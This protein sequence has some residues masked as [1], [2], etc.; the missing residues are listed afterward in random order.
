[1]ATSGI[2]DTVITWKVVNVGDF[3]FL[4]PCT[5][6]VSRMRWMGSPVVFAL[7]VWVGFFL[8]FCFLFFSRKEL[9]C[10][11]AESLFCTMWESGHQHVFLCSPTAPQPQ[12]LK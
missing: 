11:V 2:A 10:P 3:Q 9:C 4:K 5:H 8:L 7:V 1:M 6:V 12:E